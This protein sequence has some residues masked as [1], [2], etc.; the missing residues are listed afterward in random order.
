MKK[1]LILLGVSLLLL[2]GCSPKET[3]SLD[4]VKPDGSFV[5]VKTEDGYDVAPLVEDEFKYESV[6]TITN[7][8]DP[9]CGACIM[10]EDLTKDTVD[11]LMK[12]GKVAI[13]FRP[14]MFLNDGSKNDYSSRA[15]A[16]VIATAEHAPTKVYSFI[17]ELLSSEFVGFDAD[18]NLL[19]SVENIEDSKFEDLLT[20][21]GVTEEELEQITTNKERYT[22][23][24]LLGTENF[25]T[26]K[27][28]E[29]LS[30]EDYVFTPFVLVN[31]TGEFTAKALEFSELDEVASDLKVAV[32]NI[33]LN[34]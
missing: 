28:Y 29:E 2:T 8:F 6:V 11:E 14:M 31:K 12:T 3:V 1:L 10:F 30:P 20:K 16:Y 34:E 25:T 15:S 9:L 21:L 17:K 22:A 24:T 13:E 33:L 23:H 27:K 18:G 26:D 32:N 19:P 7:F 5:V 4:K